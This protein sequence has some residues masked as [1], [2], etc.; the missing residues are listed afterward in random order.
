[1]KGG[2]TGAAGGMRG[3]HI[4]ALRIGA[5][6]RRAA[7]APRRVPCCGARCARDGGVHHW[8]MRNIFEPAAAA[9]IRT[10][11]QQLRADSP[12][13]WG[14][15]TAPQMVTHCAR[16]LEMALGDL[17]PPRALIGRLFGALVKP[18]ALGNDAPF[19]RNAPTARELRITDDRDIEVERAQLLSLLDR[20][21]AGGATA[22]TDYPHAFFGA[23]TPDEW[24]VL[25]YKHLDHHL[26]QFGA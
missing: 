22:C 18:M 15:M 16:S 7:M 6:P 24:A 5:M 13:Q 21:T 23:L 8:R 9:E 26:R 10:R 19:K 17:R 14:R 20:L 2:A 12:R 11:F 1:M 3:E 4:I 25:V